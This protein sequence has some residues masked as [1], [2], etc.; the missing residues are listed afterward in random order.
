MIKLNVKKVHSKEFNLIGNVQLKD[1][2][3]VMI[4]HDLT[5]FNVLDTKVEND[6][7]KMKISTVSSKAEFEDMKYLTIDDILG[8]FVSINFGIIDIRG[9]EP[10]VRDESFRPSNEMDNIRNQT[11]TV[12]YPKGL[13]EKIENAGITNFRK[14]FYSSVGY[15][16]SSKYADYSLAKYE[17]IRQFNKESLFSFVYLHPIMMDKVTMDISIDNI[18]HFI[19]DPLVDL[20]R[21]I[22]EE[23]KKYA[24]CVFRIISNLKKESPE[25]VI[26]SLQNLAYRFSKNANIIL[27]LVLISNALEMYLT[28]SQAH[29][30]SYGRKPIME[31]IFTNIERYVTRIGNKPLGENVFYRFNENNMIGGQSIGNYTTAIVNNTRNES[32]IVIDNDNKDTKLVTDDNLKT[33]LYKDIALSLASVKNRIED[34]ETEEDRQKLV[35]EVDELANKILDA[36]VRLNDSKTTLIEFDGLDDELK[37]TKFDITNFN[38]Y[39]PEAVASKESF[40]VIAVNDYFSFGEINPYNINNSTNIKDPLK[41]VAKRAYVHT[42]NIVVTAV[43]FIFGVLRRN[44][45]QFGADLFYASKKVGNL[46]SGIFGKVNLLLGASYPVNSYGARTHIDNIRAL[47][48]KFDTAEKRNKR[49]KDWQEAK[50]KAKEKIMSTFTDLTYNED[51]PLPIEEEYKFVKVPIE[52]DMTS[53]GEADLVKDV[54]SKKVKMSFGIKRLLLSKSIKAVNKKLK[55]KKVDKAMKDKLELENTR[56]KEMMQKALRDKKISKKD[57]DWFIANCM[58]DTKG[59]KVVESKN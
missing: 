42:E 1:N 3:V 26:M 57:Y 31:S 54:M 45:D 59:L 19:I 35:K 16:I 6:V 27:P 51:Y 32:P 43:K 50:L 36:R 8:R 52:I 23:E 30:Y 25:Y 14:T 11:C 17:E 37:D 44:I 40:G 49:Y 39:S 58:Y 22:S 29:E 9:I 24:D 12:T 10:T 33:F 38:I 28:E 53:S 55:G 13:I 15:V 21:Y 34:M 4:E 47:R 20:P 48:N 41:K 46:F 56:H 2:T 5:N 18:L 7:F